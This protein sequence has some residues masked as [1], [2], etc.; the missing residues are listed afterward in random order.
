MRKLKW[1]FVAM[2]CAAQMS[3]GQSVEQ[4]FDT[5]KN[6]EGGGQHGSCRW[7]H[8]EDGEPLH[9]E[10]GRKEYRCIGNGRMFLGNEATFSTSH[11]KF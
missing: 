3:Y 1:I 5:F 11:L 6:K 2:V 4:L 7:I 10:P 9:G 8:H